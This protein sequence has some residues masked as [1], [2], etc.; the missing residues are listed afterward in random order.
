M[1]AE[2]IKKAE[3]ADNLQERNNIT[4]AKQNGIDLAEGI[5]HLEKF[6][7]FQ[8]FKD[9]VRGMDN[10]DPKRKAS[11][12]IFLTEIRYK[13]AREKL[14]NELNLWLEIVKTG[15]GNVENMKEICEEKRNKAETK[16]S[17]NLNTVRSEIADLEVAYRSLNS[18]FAN[19]G[20]GKVDYLTVIN[21][22]KEDLGD[23]DAAGTKTI[24]KEIHDN[25]DKISLKDHYS[26]LVLPGYLGDADNVRQWAKTAYEN[27][28][29]LI[30]DF[31]DSPLYDDFD[32]LKD[33]IDNAN[34]K[35]QDDF[36]SN[37]VMTCNYLL[38]RKKSEMA[39]ES[40]DLYMPGSSALA[41]KLS[42]VDSQKSGTVISQG[43]A[44][45]KYGTLDQIKGTR[46]PLLKSELI[47][48][49]NLG[50]IPMIES[51][52]RI[53]AYSN[54]TLYCGGT[55]IFQEYPIVRVFD[56]IGKEFQ[57]FF[58]K[59][60]FRNWNGDAQRELIEAVHTF[61]SS[62]KGPDKLIE[63][64]KDVKIVQDKNKDISI[65]VNI[66]PFYAASNYLIELTGHEDEDGKQSFTQTTQTAS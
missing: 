19:A 58:D 57:H 18:F 52:G 33:D 10:M 53:M 28:V 35:G 40:D 8:L 48:L 16:L 45:E 51:D 43:I 31:D 20:Q 59:Q 44:G 14:Q 55:K 2:E 29:L 36:M 4:D 9:I 65:K 22:N 47:T 1:S 41:G 3:L 42:N 34:L 66:K 27:K 49:I 32:N 26:L 60:T 7:G 61:L 13:E 50:L 5:K 39:N 25:F 23:F 30:T 12:N 6:G 56:W 15:K 17:Q 54:K 38:G 21:I 62:Q 46:L 11:K 24:R 63:N 37:V 64:Y